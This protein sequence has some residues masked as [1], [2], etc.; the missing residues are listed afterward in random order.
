MSWNDIMRRV[1]PPVWDSKN[2]RYVP[3]NVTSPYGDTN[4]PEGSSNPHKGVDFNY[5]VGHDLV[6]NKSH[7]TLRSPVTGVVTNAGEGTVGRIAIRDT[8]GF[9]HEILHTYSRHVAVGDPV[10]A[11]QII[12]TMGNTGVK[13]KN[14]KPGDPHVHYQLLDPTGK[15]I[16]PSAYWNEQGPIDPNPRRQPISATTSDICVRPAPSV[17]PPH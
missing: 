9:S 4:R 8:N 12:G 2:G 14:G 6:F 16:D 15:K 11:G 3:N 7:P 17:R 5:Y 10:V 1:L 13:G